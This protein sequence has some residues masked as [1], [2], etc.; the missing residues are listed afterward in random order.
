MERPKA[1]LLSTCGALLTILP[2]LKVS[3]YVFD[4]GKDVALT[5][6]VNKVS[7]HSTQVVTFG[8]LGLS[9]IKIILSKSPV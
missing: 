3:A 9:L 4:F 7:H 6:G 8:N 2:V 1:W 5:T